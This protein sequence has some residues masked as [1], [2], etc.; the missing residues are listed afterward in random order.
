VVDD[1]GDSHP[2]GY[3]QGHNGQSQPFG[4][5]GGAGPMGPRGMRPD[6]GNRPGSHGRNGQVP[7]DTS[8]TTPSTT[9]PTTPPPTSAPSAGGA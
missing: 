1:G 8:P 3:S 5:N 7:D 4:E 2:A 6:D 9:T